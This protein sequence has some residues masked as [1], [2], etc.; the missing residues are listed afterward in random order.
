MDVIVMMALGLMIIIALAQIAAGGVYLVFGSDGDDRRRGAKRLAMGG[1]LVLLLV[2]LAGLPA[3]APISDQG[4]GAESAGQVIIDGEML[5]GAAVPAWLWSG[6]DHPE[7]ATC[8]VE[9][10]SALCTEVGK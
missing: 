10:P 2:L 9:P 8:R 7:W 5:Q 3:C 6:A 4:D 1:A